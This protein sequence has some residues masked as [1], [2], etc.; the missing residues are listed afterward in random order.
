VSRRRLPLFLSGLILLA[1]LAVYCFVTAGSAGASACHAH[2][3]GLMVTADPQCTPGEHYRVTRRIAC[4][5][6]LHPRKDPSER[7]RH[8][9]FHRYGIPYSQHSHYEIDHRIP[10]FLRG[11]TTLRNLFPERNYR[12]R[13]SAFVWNPK[14]RLEDYVH[15]AVC[16]GRMPVG[17]A[18][19]IFSGDWR[20]AYRKYVGR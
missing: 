12:H 14:D 4:T 3:H 11:K 6:R 8:E 18:L 9:V 7:L 15:R 16:S 20:P 5:P 2:G 1:A 10:V 17:R 19:R 13:P